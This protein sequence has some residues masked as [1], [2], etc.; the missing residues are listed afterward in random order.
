MSIHTT[1]NRILLTTLTTLTLLAS[2][3]T[4]Y[5]SE[6]ET[7]VPHVAD[8]KESTLTLPITQHW[9][10]D[11]E[12]PD[13]SAHYAL[14]P[15]STSH[16]EDYESNTKQAVADGLITFQIADNALNDGAFTMNGDNA[17]VNVRFTWTSPGL[18]VFKLVGT[19]K[20]TSFYSY[21]QGA[22]LIRVYVRGDGDSFITVESPSGTKLAE[23]TLDPRYNNPKRA[24]HNGGKH[25]ST[26]AVQ[27]QETPDGMIH[28][29]AVKQWTNDDES[30]RPD[31]VTLVLTQNNV[32][33]DTILTASAET[34]WTAD[35][36]LLADDGTVWGVEELNVPDGYTVSVTSTQVNAD[37]LYTITNM[38]TETGTD[39]DHRNGYTGD[40]TNMMLYAG[41]MGAAALSLA[42]WFAVHK[43]G[44]IR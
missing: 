17:T 19:D 9:Y 32:Q 12:D 6:T 38:G 40:E 25:D 8:E 15:E 34:D 18:Y 33:T 5:A 37:L 42:A 44:A 14:T 11:G 1:L 23:L 10:I 41:I 4:A 21:D 29:A 43:N 16:Q 7:T 13:L 24:H 39:V 27:P 2:P 3:L 30:K 20:D 36:G 31:S 35:F 26:V 22:Y 28:V